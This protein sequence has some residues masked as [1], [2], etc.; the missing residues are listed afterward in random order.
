M[1]ALKQ[2][3]FLH[4]YTF[5]F[6]Y[7]LLHTFLKNWKIILYNF[8]YVLANN[9]FAEKKIANSLMSPFREKDY[10]SPVIYVH[11][12]LRSKLLYLD[13]FWHFSKALKTRTRFRSYVPGTFLS[14]KARKG[15]E[16]TVFASKM[17]KKVCACQAHLHIR[18]GGLTRGLLRDTWRPSIVY[19]VIVFRDIRSVCA[20]GRGVKEN[21][22]A[23]KK[24][25]S[26]RLN[27]PGNAK[28]E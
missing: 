11:T 10:S 22:R 13:C 7:F 3:V 15:R 5:V 6:I 25:S 26:A 16:K 19:N 17:Q 18:V 14:R 8:I 1:I 20:G 27:A 4:K 28:G 24:W 23:E 21:E 12:N 2:S 9:I